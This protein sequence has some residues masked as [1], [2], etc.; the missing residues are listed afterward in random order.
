MVIHHHIGVV[1]FLDFEIFMVLKVRGTPFSILTVT[2]HALLPRRMIQVVIAAN[3]DKQTVTL[4]DLTE[5][6]TLRICL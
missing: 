1:L 2:K 3:M 6:V 5:I 4:V